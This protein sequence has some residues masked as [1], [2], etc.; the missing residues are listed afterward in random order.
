MGDDDW[1]CAMVLLVVA[2]SWFLVV[3]AAIILW[4]TFI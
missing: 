2:L 3:A 4:L 1:T